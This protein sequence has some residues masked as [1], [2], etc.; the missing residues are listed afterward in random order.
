MSSSLEVH[1]A[2]FPIEQGHSGLSTH[3]AYGDSCL[4]KVTCTSAID[5]KGLITDVRASR[6]LTC[7]SIVLHN[8]G[9][10]SNCSPLH[11]IVATS[12]RAR[13]R[14]FP[15]EEKGGVA[16]GFVMEVAAVQGPKEAPL[17]QP[18]FARH[19]F[20]VLVMLV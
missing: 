18:F 19:P 9:A 14:S 7:E 17:R 12:R 2:S 20:A 15:R 4:A 8:S 1:V 10:R 11:S 16:L 6:G 13:G 5:T 3:S